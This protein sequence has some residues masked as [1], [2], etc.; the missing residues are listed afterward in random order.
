MLKNIIIEKIKNTGP[1]SFHDFMETCLYYPGMG[2]YTSPRN[3]IGKKGDYYT[4]SYVTPVFGVMIAR[5]L[6]EMWKILGQKKFM[7]IEYGAGTGFLACDILNSIKCNCKFYDSL[8]YYIIEKSPVMREIEKSILPEKVC[9]YNS[10]DEIPGEISGCVLSNELL[11]NF[12]VHQVI[13][14]DELMEIFVDYENNFFEVLKP[15][16]ELLKNYLSEL[17]VSLPKSYRTEINLE[18]ISWIKNIADRMKEGFV[19]TIDYGYPSR[20]LYRSYRN[21]GTLMC[22]YNHA[23][24]ENPFQH[25]GEQDITAHVNFSALYHE[26]KKYGLDGC[27]LT[28]QADFL[29]NLGIEEYL[30]EIKLH[31]QLSSQKELLLKKILLEDMGR[32][33]KVFIQRKGVVEQ[34]LRGL[35]VQAAKQKTKEIQT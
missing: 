15:A 21:R 14:D 8:E 30:E 16:G 27:G 13:M 2:Y 28:D 12:S 3:K 6:E 34:E 17:G 20:E 5:Q 9:W 26:G 32:K 4:S 29:S 19:I 33:F 18:A 1:I 24:G 10:I 31:D 11:D 7:V 25:I 35:A 23:V 22:Y